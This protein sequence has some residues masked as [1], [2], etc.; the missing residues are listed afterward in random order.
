MAT[1]RCHAE[2]TPLHVVHALLNLDEVASL[3]RTVGVDVA[4]LRAAAKRGLKGQSRAAHKSLIEDKTGDLIRDAKRGDARDLMRVASRE[5]DLFDEFSLSHAVIR[6]LMDGTEGQG[7]LLARVPAPARRRTLFSKR[8]K[9]VPAIV[10]SLE[11]Y[12]PDA[13]GALQEAQRIADQR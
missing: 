7:Q 4:K 13:K 11:G 8:P 5:L 6:T 1:K 2:V 3:V 10:L 12:E 9:E